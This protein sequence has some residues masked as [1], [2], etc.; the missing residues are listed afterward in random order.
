MRQKISNTLLLCILH[1]D[2]IECQSIYVL[3]SY[4]RIISVYRMRITIAYRITR[5]P[6]LQIYLQTRV[7]VILDKTLTAGNLVHWE[8]RFYRGKNNC[9]CIS[10]GI[11]ILF[12]NYD[13]GVSNELPHFL[14]LAI[15]FLDHELK[16]RSIS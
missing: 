15:V 3:Y 1:P 8:T 4:I 6:V 14:L 7:E 5:C 12:Q 16:S 13:K 2:N 10:Q 11:M 9:G